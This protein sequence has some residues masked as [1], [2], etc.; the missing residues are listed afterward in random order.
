MR[1]VGGRPNQLLYR[2]INTTSNVRSYIVA[3][4][5]F[6]VTTC[7]NVGAGVAFRKFRRSVIFVDEAGKAMDLDVVL[8]LAHY[9]PRGLIVVGDNRQLRRSLEIQRRT[10]VL[11]PFWVLLLRVCQVH[12][13]YAT[14]QRRRSWK[15]YG[16]RRRHP[17]GSPQTPNSHP[18]GRRS[19]TARAVQRKKMDNCL[20][21]GLCSSYLGVSSSCRICDVSAFCSENSID[22]LKA[23]QLRLTAQRKRRRLCP[24]HLEF[25]FFQHVKFL[26]RAPQHPSQKATSTSGRSRR[27]AI[28]PL[29]PWLVA[30]I[31]NCVPTR[32]AQS[33]KMDNRTHSSRVPLFQ[34]L[35]LLY[36][37]FRACYEPRAS[38][39]VGDRRQR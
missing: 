28:Q 7:S 24:P 16:S 13:V 10:T 11:T 9:E 33:K 23:W 21:P 26:Y 31:V 20:Q 29:L 2:P 35:K 5:H 17:I 38:I 3:N 36:T 18:G 4:A 14:C 34:R 19:A 15:S 39:L 27:V 6:V 12:T 25:P 37:A 8:L 22:K 1:G 32:N 30:M